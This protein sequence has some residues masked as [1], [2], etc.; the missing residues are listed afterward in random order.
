MP[1]RRSSSASSVFFTTNAAHVVDEI[2]DLLLP[3]YVTPGGK[4]AV[5][6]GKARAVVILNNV[7][8]D[9]VR[10]RLVPDVRRYIP[11]R[12]G[13]LRASFGFKRL[14]PGRAVLTLVRHGRYDNARYKGG[15]A[16]VREIIIEQARERNFWLVGDGPQLAANYLIQ[17]GNA[18]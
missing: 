1:R 17:R 13:K 11:K 10:R 4:A 3:L 2:I 15:D 7:V 16:S 8:F 14:E 12:T 9:N 18:G 5:R 6:A